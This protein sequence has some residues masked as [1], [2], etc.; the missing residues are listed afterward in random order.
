MAS[1]LERFEKARTESIQLRA[2]SAAAVNSMRA[3]Q[4][5]IRR[6]LS[7][8]EELAS[9]SAPA[10]RAVQSPAE[11]MFTMRGPVSAD[12]SREP[13]TSV[14]NPAEHGRPLLRLVAAESGSVAV[15][16]HQPARQ[17]FEKV[18]PWV[19]APQREALVRA[20]SLR[21]VRKRRPIATDAEIRSR[22]HLLVSGQAKFGF[23]SSKGT[24]RLIAIL[25]SG[26]FLGA[27]HSA[28]QEPNHWEYAIKAFYCDAISDCV[29]AELDPLE[30]Y[31][32]IDD[33]NAH[34]LL[35]SIQHSADPWLR[36]FIWRLALSELDV[37]SRVLANLVA[38]AKRFGVPSEQGLTINVKLAQIDLA[39]L[40]G[41]S[42]PKVSTCLTLLGREGLVLRD[43]RRLTITTKAMQIAAP[44]RPA[45]IGAKRRKLNGRVSSFSLTRIKKSPLRGK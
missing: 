6:T 18:L 8:F 36:L 21:S 43:R 31:A 40:V 28:M 27:L 2:A 22:L 11:H 17:A 32:L 45:G 3:M 35:K 34:A 37:R 39:Q 13:T 15:E 16:E 7:S 10:L 42:R 33:A 12:A 29:V 26:D 14:P 30:L 38:L 44:L 41:A 19:S 4:S 9:T 5:L 1:N 25:S 24:R 23:V 20:V